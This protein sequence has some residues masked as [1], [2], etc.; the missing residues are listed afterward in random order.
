MRRLLFAVMLLAL[1]P[2]GAGSAFADESTARASASA[3][4]VVAEGVTI[5]GLDVG[6][7][8]TLEAQEAVQRWFASPGAA[9]VQGSHGFARA[10]R[11]D[12]RARALAGRAAWTAIGAAPG[13][14]ARA[15]REGQALW[16]PPLREPRSESGSTA[17]RGTPGSSS[18]TSGPGSREAKYGRRVIQAPASGRASPG[19]LDAHAR[20]DPDPDEAGRAQSVTRA[21]LRPDRSSSGA[22]RSSST[23]TAGRSFRAQLRRRH[24]P[25]AVPDSARSLLDRDDA[26]ESVVVSAGLRLGVRRASRSRPGPGNPLGTRWMGLS[27]GGVG[28]HGTPDCGLDRLLGLARL[29][30][31]ADPGRGVALRARSRRHAGLHRRRVAVRCGSGP[32]RADTLRRGPWHA[33]ANSFSRRRRS[34][35][36]P[37][38]LA[39]FAWRLVDGGPGRGARRR[40]QRTASGRPL[41]A[42]RSSGSTARGRSRSLRCAARL[43]SSTSGP[44]GASRARRSRRRSR[45]SGGVPRPRRRLRRR[46]TRWTH[47][48]EARHFAE[49]FGLSYPLVYDG[50]GKTVGRYGVTRRFRRPG[51]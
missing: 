2:S 9:Q 6:G 42:S 11:D 37:L 50:P 22:A 40:R 35:S 16:N 3:A 47:V 32:K 26:A 18:A 10:P 8:T 36:S 38:L 20:P 44:R 17:L 13:Y 21:E 48:G 15:R 14:R 39:L 28:I 30:P 45:A 27:V 33:A 12:L 7:L 4:P 46:S 19:R 41:R 23:S 31:H 5:A 43:S 1:P 49:R 25:P 29:H 34:V 51:S 24:G